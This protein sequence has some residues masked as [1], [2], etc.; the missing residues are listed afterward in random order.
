MNTHFK[1]II[2]PVDGSQ[3]ASRAAAFAADLAA[4]CGCPLKLLH[5]YSPEPGEV[6]GM[7]GLD[8]EKI[9]QI[10]RESAANAFAAAREQISAE[11][12]EV[13]EKVV[14]GEPRGEILAAAESDQALV[15]MGR[16]G[17]GRVQ[18]LLLGSVS[19]AVLHAS[20]RPVTL[21]N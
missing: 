12:V 3:G 8:R 1:T 11:G 2:V 15:V 18:G 13:E 21:V 5:V 9:E 19:A 14:W 7:V 16:R 20:K 10:G 6:L 4:Q 17:L